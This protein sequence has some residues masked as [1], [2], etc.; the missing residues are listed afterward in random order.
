MAE[1]LQDRNAPPKKRRIGR[2]VVVLL[3]V[4]GIAALVLWKR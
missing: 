3:V 2:L 1:L 4:A